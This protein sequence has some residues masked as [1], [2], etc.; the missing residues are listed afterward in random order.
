MQLIR[1]HFFLVTALVFDERRVIFTMMW[2]L[3]FIPWMNAAAVLHITVLMVDLRPAFFDETTLQFRNS[4][5]N[6]KLNIEGIHISTKRLS[7]FW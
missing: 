3:F 6:A 1:I 7:A 4:I 5:G 2:I